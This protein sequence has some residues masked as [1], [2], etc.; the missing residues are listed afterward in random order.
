MGTQHS[1]TVRARC[2]T[3]GQAT[4]L[5]TQPLPGT[6]VPPLWRMRKGCSS[7]SAASCSHHKHK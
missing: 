1:F 5:L 2:N 7:A 3:T 6:S 4:L